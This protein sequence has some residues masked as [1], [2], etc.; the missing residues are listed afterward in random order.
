MNG[1]NKIRKTEVSP[2]ENAAQKDVINPEIDESNNGDGKDISDITGIKQM[3]SMEHPLPAQKQLKESKPQRGWNFKKIMVIAFL[4]ILGVGIF[5]IIN[6]FFGSESTSQEEKMQSLYIIDTHDFLSS[7]YYNC[8]ALVNDNPEF[9]THNQ[10]KKECIALYT[11][12]IS[13]LKDESYCD[14]LID[15]QKVICTAFHSKD[16]SL[17]SNIVDDTYK[18]Y[19][20]GVVTQDFDYCNMIKENDLVNSDDCKARNKFIYAVKEKD[21]SLCKNA[22]TGDFDMVDLCKAIILKDEEYCITFVI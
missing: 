14:N 3:E 6:T 9:C 20:F 19:C 2:W 22:K 10:T 1:K 21:I 17:C 18:N 8:L 16:S 7:E 12:D 4:I 11:W 15:E 5:L 13:F